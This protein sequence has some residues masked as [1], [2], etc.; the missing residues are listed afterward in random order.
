MIAC[1]LLL[2]VHRLRTGKF[3]TMHVITAVVVLILG[4]ATLWK[5]PLPALKPTV[6]L[7]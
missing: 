2:V 4:A 7:R 3:K 1:V 6:L 5:Q